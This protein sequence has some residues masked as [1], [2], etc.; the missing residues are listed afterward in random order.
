MTIINL[1][2]M[3]TCI[4]KPHRCTRV[5][6]LASSYTF[7]NELTIEIDYIVLSLLSFRFF[8]INVTYWTKFQVW[9]ILSTMCLEHKFDQYQCIYYVLAFFT[10]WIDGIWNKCSN[11]FAVIYKK[12]PFPSYLQLLEL[13]LYYMN[14]LHISGYDG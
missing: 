1:F 10:K 3:Y 4:Q 6:R 12:N 13:Q 7:L 11:V 8:F 14:I 2:L 9:K 5:I